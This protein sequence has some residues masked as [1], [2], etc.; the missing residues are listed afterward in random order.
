MLDLAMPVPMDG[1]FEDE[2]TRLDQLSMS[3]SVVH[4]EWAMMISETKKRL[5]RLLPGDEPQAE[6]EEIQHHLQSRLESWLNKSLILVAS[7]PSNNRERLSAQ[8]KID[9]HFAVGLIY[10][11]S[12]S[13]P[14]PSDRALE[15]CFSSAKQRIRL[16]DLLYCQNNLTFNWPGTHGVF[17]A[18][19]TYIYSIWA[20][21]AIRSSVSPAEVAGDLRL[22]SSL[23]ALGGEWYPLAQRGKGAS[24]S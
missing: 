23:L 18:G 14:H 16:F 11:P 6:I 12:R 2:S 20:S 21:T 13:C 7:V 10:Q 8:F 9:Y 24:S 1:P 17:L 5:Y 4:F 3:C 19:A 15:I 22:V